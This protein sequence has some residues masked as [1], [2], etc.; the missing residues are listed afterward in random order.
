[1]ALRLVII[2]IFWLPAITSD[3][4]FPW[5]II[6]RSKA[7]PR[8]A[9]FVWITALGKILKI[10]HLRKRKVRIIDL[11]YVCKC[12]GEFVDHLLLHCPITSD[13][14]SL[15]LGLWSLI[16]GLY[17]VYWV[18]PK[19]VVELLACWQGRFARHQNGHI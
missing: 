19:S 11:C 17:G 5:K 4:S 14:W 7:P 6:W 2:T 3:C 16:S 8:V 9:F 13:L 1:M 18:M 10:D 12:N 15:I